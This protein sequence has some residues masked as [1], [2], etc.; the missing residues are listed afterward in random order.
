MASRLATILP[1]IV[2][3]QQYG[4]VQGRSIHEYIALAQE[5]VSELDRKTDGGNVI[6][7][8]AMSKAYDRLECGSYCVRFELWVSQ[9]LFRT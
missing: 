5:M 9:I 1:L 6:L 3:G 2:N 8:F 4:F 7:M